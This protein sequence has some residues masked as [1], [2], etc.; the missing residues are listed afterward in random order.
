MNYVLASD[1]AGKEIF[2]IKIFDVPI[3][4]KMEEDVQ[5]IFITDL[6]LSG[7]A[8]LVRDEKDR[9]FAVDLTTRAVKKKYLC[10]F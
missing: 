4:P 5:W 3:D 10:S 1:S 6:K 9:C 8:L 2:R 7:N